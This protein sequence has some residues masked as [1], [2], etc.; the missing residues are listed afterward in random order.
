MSN[1]ALR[2]IFQ[3]ALGYAKKLV[4]RR[5]GFMVPNNVKSNPVISMKK[6]IAFAIATMFVGN[7]FAAEFPDMTIP[8][9]KAA[10]DSGKATVIDVN[11]TKSYKKG[12]IPTAIN[13]DEH[14]KNFAAALPKDKN[15]LIVAYC[16]GPK[17]KA[18]KEAASAAEKLGYK[19]VKHL[20]AG[21]AGWK[22]AGEKS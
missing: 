6:I 11:G 3:V 16:G 22:S 18:Y 17:C 5:F 8:E 4:E 20:S 12:H 10:I 21:I 14:E 19:N 1:P 2:A 7:V 9:L 15:A 13:F